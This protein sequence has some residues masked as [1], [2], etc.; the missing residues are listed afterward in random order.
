MRSAVLT[1][2]LAF[3]CGYC[4]AQPPGHV[5][6][7]TANWNLLGLK[8]E[9]QVKPLVW[10]TV[11]P[12]ELRAI[13]N[14]VIELPGYIIPTK[15]GTDFSEFMFSIVPLESCPYCGSGDI[16]SMIEVK[17]KHPIEWTDKPVKIR[18][19]LLINDSGDDRS[20]F[21]LLNAVQI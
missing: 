3:T 16:P 6:L 12:P 15:V 17:M 9:K 21:F 18:G 2:V 14:K 19:K 13:N 11:F 20:E 8:Y 5:N 4:F 1:I 10:Q 7:R